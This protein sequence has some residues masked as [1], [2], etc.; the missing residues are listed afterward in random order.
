MSK[1]E[2]E[3]EGSGSGKGKGAWKCL[4]VRQTG[5]IQG[6]RNN[7]LTLSNALCWGDV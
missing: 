6:S 3:R 5:N 7:S 4:H 2:V 1:M